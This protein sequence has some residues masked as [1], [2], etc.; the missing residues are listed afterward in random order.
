MMLQYFTDMYSWR[1][2]LLVIS[3]VVFNQFAC[4]LMSGPSRDNPTSHKNS[5][6]QTNPQDIYENN[7]PTHG[8]LSRFQTLLKNKVFLSYCFALAFA[9]A[10]FNS[11][12]IFFIDYFEEKGF[13]RS[14]VVWLYTGMNIISTVFRFIPG[15]MA[16]S[17]KIPKLAIPA[18]YSTLGFCSLA[19][20]PFVTSYVLNAVVV[21]CYGVGLG[22]VVT[23]LSII[24]MELVGDENYPTAYGMV[25]ATVG[26]VNT[27]GAPIT[28][29]ISVVFSTITIISSVQRKINIICMHFK[30]ARSAIEEKYK[31]ISKMKYMYTGISFTYFS[32]ILSVLV[33]ALITSF[34]SN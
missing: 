23:V 28:G 20:L 15:I 33:L 1:G 17:P 24:T 21:G 18:M 30:G 31:Y 32:C 14:A 8:C 10:A 13:D 27:A 26:I 2:C 5:V 4:G 22:G 3:G 19:V 34:K 11:F 9:L 29:N 6:P 16:Q 7:E 12:L 25:L